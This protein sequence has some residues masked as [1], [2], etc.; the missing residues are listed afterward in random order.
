[1]SIPDAAEIEEMEVQMRELIGLPRDWKVKV[2]VRPY[3]FYDMGYAIKKEEKTVEIL[4]YSAQ[5][6]FSYARWHKN[7]AIEVANKLGCI[8]SPKATA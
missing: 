4:V 1:M 6:P 5:F 3:L 8:P 2:D 7:V